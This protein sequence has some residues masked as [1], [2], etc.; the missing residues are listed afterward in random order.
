VNQALKDLRK[1]REDH[2]KTVESWRQHLGKSKA[3]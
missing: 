1:A 3:I 2:R